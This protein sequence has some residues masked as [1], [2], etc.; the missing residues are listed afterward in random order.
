MKKQSKYY[1][2]KQGDLFE[3]LKKLFNESGLKEID[4][5]NSL[6]YFMAKDMEEQARTEAKINNTAALVFSIIT[7]GICIASFW[8]HGLVFIGFATL[9]LAFKFDSNARIARTE[10]ELYLSE[11]LQHA[12]AFNNKAQEATK[13]GKKHSK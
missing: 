10:V 13:N 11:R 3:T 8:V 2:H 1:E 5:V 12:R 7:L 9:V 6:A 4:L